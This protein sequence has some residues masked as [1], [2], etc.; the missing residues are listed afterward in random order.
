MAARCMQGFIQAEWLHYFG[1]PSLEV[2]VILVAAI[3][4][5]EHRA[6]LP[7]LIKGRDDGYIL[8]EA[9]FTHIWQVGINIM[10]NQPMEDGRD[11][12]L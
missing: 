10:I 11:V 2:I 7:V 8:T 4:M 5:S 6:Y 3:L 12:K 9:S 1:E